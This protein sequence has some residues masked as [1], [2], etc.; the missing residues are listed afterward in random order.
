MT[1][2]GDGGGGDDDDDD[3]GCGDRG[4]QTPDTSTSSAL[5]KPYQSGPSSLPDSSLLSRRPVIR[6]VGK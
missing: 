3:L 6:P 1:T 4:E 5:S 2:T